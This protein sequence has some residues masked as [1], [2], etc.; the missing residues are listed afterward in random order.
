MRLVDIVDF[1][2]IV[3]ICMLHMCVCVWYM[4]L[5]AIPELEAHTFFLLLL[6]AL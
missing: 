2:Y 6:R 3:D 4:A 1:G 5:A